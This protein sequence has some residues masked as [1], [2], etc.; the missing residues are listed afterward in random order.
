MT[1]MSS[2]AQ[3]R[4][5][6]IDARQA[7]QALQD[8]VE[9]LSLLEGVA[10]TCLRVVKALD[11]LSALPAMAWRDSEAIVVLDEI[12]DSDVVSDLE[13]RFFAATENLE[14]GE[15]GR[16]LAQLLEK[17]ERRYIALLESLHSLNAVLR[18]QCG[19]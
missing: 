13:G 10:E 8:W 9:D 16:L 6:L 12:V 4:S 18:L 14:E 2:E 5:L 11:E 15:L 17:T 1:L 3:V 7:A 19:S